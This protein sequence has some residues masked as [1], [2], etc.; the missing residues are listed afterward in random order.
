MAAVGGRGDRQQQ[1]AALRTANRKLVAFLTD[2]TGS[3]VRA[4]RD[5]AQDPRLGGLLALEA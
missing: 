4:A 2:A 5:P 3:L 1:I